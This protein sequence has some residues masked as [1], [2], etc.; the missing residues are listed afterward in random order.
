MIEIRNLKKK[1]GRFVAIEDFTLGL[2]EGKIYGILGKVNSG[3]TTIFNIL[4]N[5]IS[6]IECFFFL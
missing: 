2:T 3:G 5:Y 6:H 4:C 1:Y